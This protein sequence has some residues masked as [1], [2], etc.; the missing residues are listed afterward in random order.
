MLR[1]FLMSAVVLAVAGP[2]LADDMDV[3]RD[4]QSE[5]K[6]RL[7]ACEKIIAAGQTTD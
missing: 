2:A 6:P 7:E 3:C 1:A 4:K 5:P